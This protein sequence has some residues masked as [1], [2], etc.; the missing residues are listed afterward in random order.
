[1]SDMNTGKKGAPRVDMTPMVDLGFLLITF[2]ML[3]T[4]F[5]KPQTMEINMPDKT[6]KNDEQKIKESK[7]LTIILGRNN[8]VYWYQGLNNPTVNITDF[9][10]KGLRKLVVDKQREVDGLIILI[11]PMKKSRFKNVVDILDE[12]TIVGAER[13]SLVDITEEDMKLVQAKDP[14]GV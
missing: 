3:T 2:F 10:D 8:K 12:M 11:K 1:M 4:T 9:S 13:Y 6:E 5:N 14:S 7:A